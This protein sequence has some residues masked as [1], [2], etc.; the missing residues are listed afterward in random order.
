MDVGLFVAQG[1]PIQLT[2][3]IAKIDKGLADLTYTLFNSSAGAIGSLDLALIDFNSAGKL[4]WV[5]SWSMQTKVGASERQSFSINLR[6]RVTPG[7]RLVLCVEAVR[8]DADVWQADF[9]ELVQA[10]G[11]A[12][13]GAKASPLE[14][15]RHG[16][17]MPESFGGAYC[18]D[19][20][21]K[22]F[23]LANSGDGKSFTSFTCDRNR[24]ITAFT[25]SAKSLV[26]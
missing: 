9:N 20:L 17:K 18:S 19:A 3:V 10:I 7:D 22:A 6:H 26:K 1:M 5:Q 13:T 4:M 14:V 15:K 16:E 11:V 23:Q 2:A 21:A 24:R 25:F 12:T 8:G